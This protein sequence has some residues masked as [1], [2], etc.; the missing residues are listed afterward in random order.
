MRCQW[1]GPWVGQ[2]TILVQSSQEQ[3]LVLENK[4]IW[5]NVSGTNNQWTNSNSLLLIIYC[6]RFSFASQTSS[7]K[8]VFLLDL[9]SY[10]IKLLWYQ[11]WTKSF[12]MKDSN[13]KK[14][15]ADKCTGW[16]LI[17]IE[18]NF[19]KIKLKF[20]LNYKNWIIWEKIFNVI[21]LWF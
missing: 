7:W 5:G 19:M 8:S 20:N 21:K 14:A 4:L 18:R 15:V 3:Q 1:H 9:Y 17:E 13:Y 6:T 11:I 2:W 12:F 16:L 10:W